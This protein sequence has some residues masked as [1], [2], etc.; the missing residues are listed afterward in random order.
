MIWVEVLDEPC[1]VTASDE[2]CVPAAGVLSIAQLCAA[3]A[4]SASR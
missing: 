4:A 3:D 2:L 1:V